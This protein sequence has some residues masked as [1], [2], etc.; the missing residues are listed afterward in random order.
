[1]DKPTEPTTEMPTEDRHAKHESLMHKHIMAK[2]EKR[3]EHNHPAR[4]K[5]FPLGAL[6]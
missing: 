5:K 2:A 6:V 1:M 4:K 3:E